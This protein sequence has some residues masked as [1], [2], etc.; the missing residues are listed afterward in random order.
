MFDDRCEL[1]QKAWEKAEEYGFTTDNRL[2]VD[3]VMNNPKKVAAIMNS[4]SSQG[5]IF[6]YLKK[7]IY[8]IE[9]KTEETENK[10]E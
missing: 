6:R 3:R 4:M 1:D 10:L 8:P 2:T 5:D 7:W 9:E